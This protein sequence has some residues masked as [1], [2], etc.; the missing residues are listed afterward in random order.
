LKCIFKKISRIFIALTINTLL[1]FTLFGANYSI[2]SL[3]ITGTLNEDGSLYIAEE[4]IYYGRSLNGIIQEIDYRGYGQI[5]L[6][7]ILVE[8]DES[9][10]ETIKENIIT[11]DGI[12]YLQ[13]GVE[14]V[15]GLEVN[16][17]FPIYSDNFSSSFGDFEITN[18]GQLAK[19]RLYA[20]TY[21]RERKFIFKYTL[22]HGITLYND[23]GQLNRKFVGQNWDNI[24]RVNVTIYLPSKVEEDKLYAF[25]HGPLTGEIDIY[26]GQRIHLKLNKYYTRDFVEANILFPANIINRNYSGPKIDRDGLEE[27]LANEKHLVD[28]ANKARRRGNM[29]FALL[30]GG[31]IIGVVFNI[32]IFI[33]GNKKHKGRSEYGKYFRELPDDYT[34]AVAGTLIDGKMKPNDNQLLASLFDLVQKKYLKLEETE[35]EGK[36]VLVKSNEERSKPLNEYENF[37]LDWYINKLGD[38]TRVVLEEVNLLLNKESTSRTFIESHNRWSQMVTNDM[39]NKKLTFEKYRP[40]IRKLATPLGLVFMVTGV[41][42]FNIANNYLGDLRA[43]FLIFVFLGFIMMIRSMPQTRATQY[44]ADAEERWESFKRYIVDYSRLE[45]AKLAAIHLWEH[46]FVY[47]VALGVAE[48]VLNQ[49]QELLKNLPESAQIELKR[50][51]PLMGSFMTNRNYSKSFMPFQRAT[52]AT[53]A[54]NTIAKEVRKRNVSNSRSSSSRGRGGG[55]SG[56]SSGGGGSRG[57]GRGF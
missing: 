15:F 18:S 55:F 7:E 25:A 49:F 26:D 9:S 6:H 48:R 44:R 1:F 28:E 52:K 3:N 33:H 40:F 31:V 37:L 16:P 46:Y 8:I 47:A 17:N 51:Y 32:L 14:K 11:E 20:R 53:Q 54:A 34:P 45:E 42:G 38:G 23:I 35:R 24:E 4:V 13:I 50:N 2:K 5:T 10:D 21:G 41:L 12:R 19:I 36:T 30:F 43:V 27:I 56:G 57:G 22:P 29:F 39:I